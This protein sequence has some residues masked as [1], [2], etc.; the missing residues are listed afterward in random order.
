MAFSPFWEDL[1]IPIV[2]SSPKIGKSKIGKYRTH[3]THAYSFASDHTHS[4]P[5]GWGVGG[6][7]GAYNT[8][9]FI[10]LFWPH[11]HL[12]QKGGG[13]CLKYPLDPPMKH[14]FSEYA[15]A[16]TTSLIPLLTNF[17][18]IYAFIIGFSFTV[19]TKTRPLLA[20][21]IKIR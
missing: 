15:K 18:V 16:I 19:W 10:F 11:P 13:M 6:G 9:I 20:H 8:C 21:E 1:P 12:T 17:P 2:I 3:S 7:G 4:D 14:V 5:K